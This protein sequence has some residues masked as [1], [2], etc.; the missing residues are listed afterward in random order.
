MKSFVLTAALCVVGLAFGEGRALAAPDPIVP[1]DVR[2]APQPDSRLE[3]GHPFPH[4]TF[5]WLALQMLPS[6]ELAIG[7]QRHIDASGAVDA[8]PR[9]A[10]GMRWQL[11]PL[12]WSFG[13]HRSQ[14]RF[15]SF[16]VDPLARQSGSIELSTTF[17]Y[18]G[19]DVDRVLVRPG[20]R[21]YLPLIQKGEYLSASLGTSVYAFDYG[22]RVA[23]DVGVY[24]LS[25][26]LGFQLTV[27]PT[28]APLAAITTIRLRYF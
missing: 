18:I 10:F 2:R 14:P 28:H 19:G 3:Y 26:F 12:L 13:V 24:T 16:V 21:T 4:P 8:G 23:Y 9:A 27:A 11:T 7:R 15:R 6:P 20:V 1:Q 22:L 25:G 17:E 5:A